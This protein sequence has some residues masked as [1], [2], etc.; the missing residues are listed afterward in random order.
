MRN[1]DTHSKPGLQLIDSDMLFRKSMNGF[2]DVTLEALDVLKSF[3]PPAQDDAIHIDIGGKCRELAPFLKKDLGIEY[4][5]IVSAVEQFYPDNKIKLESWN[6]QNQSDFLASLKKIA[7]G[8]R[9]SSFSILDS[10][11]FLYLNN[12]LLKIVVQLSKEHDAYILLGMP[13]SMCFDNTARLMLGQQANFQNKID[14]S[15]AG[16]VL[17]V[18]TFEQEL[19]TNGLHIVDKTNILSKKKIDRDSTDHPI[20]DG[21]TE[22]GNFFRYIRSI[23]DNDVSEISYFLRLCLAG[24]SKRNIKEDLPTPASSRPFLSVI[25]RTQGKRLHTLCEALLSLYAQTE[26]D[27]EIL[28]IGHKLDDDRIS[29]VSKIIDE[30]TLEMRQK[31]RLILVEKGN[32]TLPLNVGFAE[33]KGRY[34]SIFDDDDVVFANW[35][36]V[37]KD[38]HKSSPGRLLRSLCVRQSVRN[39]KVDGQLGLRAE[40]SPKRLYADDFDIFQHLRGNNTPNTSLAFP[41]GAFH[42]LG[43]KFDETLTTTEDWDFILRVAL[44]LG[45]ANSKI[46]TCIYRWWE[47]DESSRTEHS[48]REWQKN[49]SIIQ[50]KIDAHPILLPAGS[51]KRIRSLLDDKDRLASFEEHLKSASFEEHLRKVETQLADLEHQ[52][53]I[54]VSLR[55]A[56][57]IPRP[58][59]K[60]IRGCLYFMWK[61]L[62]VKALFMWRQRR[63]SC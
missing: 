58:V 3:I 27:F 34:I 7:N 31:T 33:A 11:D 32:R 4:A 19:S 25:M 28:I 29:A 9:I 35:I 23:S 30:Q 26:K 44:L 2:R 60:I 36:E 61:Y 62:G 46:V 55:I 37:F 42:D 59:R 41:R 16:L 13:N 10:L 39:A 38:L 56:R 53:R 57:L 40:D 21:N 1:I 6:G 63:S 14:G 12:H 52:V 54:S 47:N 24:Q 45:V 51:S 17:S 15:S 8:R 22:L 20:A 5:A 18:D 48:E 43:L 49:Y 50:D